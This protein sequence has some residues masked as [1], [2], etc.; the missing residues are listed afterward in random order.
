MLCHCLHRHQGV[1]FL[2]RQLPDT[3]QP[4]QVGIAALGLGQKRQVIAL[5]I[6]PRPGPS[7]GCTQHISPRDKPAW[8]VFGTSRTGSVQADLGA[9]D[10]LEPPLLCRPPEAYCAVQAIVIGK[11]ERP[12]AQLFSLPDQLL[13]RRGAVEQRKITMAM[14]FNVSHPRHGDPVPIAGSVIDPGQEPAAFE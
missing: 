7:T 4:A 14:Q 6:P 10:G 11:G 3:D 9:N 5:S 12:V 13:R 1:P 2:P 8:T